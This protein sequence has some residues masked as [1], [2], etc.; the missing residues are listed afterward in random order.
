MRDGSKYSAPARKVSHN[1][2]R[3]ENLAALHKELTYLRSYIDTVKREIGPERHFN[4]QEVY[5]KAARVRSGRN[6]HSTASRH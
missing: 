5:V 1:E 2:E 3:S 4:Q 6:G